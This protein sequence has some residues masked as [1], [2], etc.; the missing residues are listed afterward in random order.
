MLCQCGQSVWFW[1]QPKQL[2]ALFGP[3]L[4]PFS[5]QL[6]TLCAQHTGQKY[7]VQ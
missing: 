7:T 1:Q 6:S 4:S 2:L 5:G 3:H